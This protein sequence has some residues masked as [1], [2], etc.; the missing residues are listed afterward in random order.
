MAI[1]YIEV[2]VLSTGRG[3][4]AVGLGAYICR[5][6]W[7]SH[8]TGETYNFLPEE[9]KQAREAAALEAAAA[10]IDAEKRNKRKRKKG[11][12][13]E[14][15]PRKKRRKSDIVG[16]PMIFLPTGAPKRFKDP[17]TLWRAAEAAEMTVDRE[18]GLPRPKKKATLAK[19]V[20][21]ALPKNITDDERRDLLRAWVEHAYPGVAVMAVIHEADDPEIGN[22]H[23]HLLIST[24]T[25]DA[26]GFG[27]K[28]T[29]LEPKFSYR[30]GRSV[31]VE[32]QDL[33][34]QWRNFQN[35]FF[36]DRGIPLVVDA[37]IE[38]GGVHWG[39]ARFIPDSVR[40][41]N[42]EI[43]RKAARDRI[44]D[45][46]NL[47]ADALRNRATFT[48]RGLRWLLKANNVFGQEASD[49]INRV[50]AD[51]EVIPL[52]D[53]ETGKPLKVYTTNAVRNQERLILETARKLLGRKPTKR[54]LA[55]LK[56]DM[57]G[58]IAAMTFSSEQEVAYEHLL[59]SGRIA[60]CR[61]IAGAGKSHVIKG[62]KATYEAAGLRVV[63]LAPTNKVVNTMRTEGFSYANTLHSERY[64]L[65]HP[66]RN[67]LLWNANTVVVVDE[68]GMIDSGMM[69]WLIE[70]AAKTGAKLILVGDE[71]QLTSVERGGMFAILKKELGA[72]ELKEV[73]RQDESW[74]KEA[75]LALSEGRM[76][77]A[78]EAYAARDRIHWSDDLDGAM[79]RLVLRWSE[80]FAL[81]PDTPK[82]VYCATNVVANELNNRLQAIQFAGRR[83]FM[84]FTCVRGKIRLFPEDQV[85]FH[86]TDKKLG[87]MNGAAG[88]V[89]SMAPDEIVVETD[90]GNMITFDPTVFDGWGLGRCGTVY[91]GQG[92]T[93]PRTYALY[94]RERAWS[95]RSAY[96]AM[97]RHRKGFDL[98][99]PKSLASDLGQLGRQMSRGDDSEA[100]L[101][102]ASR[103]E[104]ATLFP[105]ALV[106]AVQEHGAPREVAAGEAAPE[107]LADHWRL[108]PHW[109]FARDYSALKKAAKAAS[110]YSL[111]HA[112]F[113]GANEA[114]LDRGILPKTGYRDPG[115]LKDFLPK[116][117]RMDPALI[118][119]KGGF[120]VSPIVV[121]IET[122]NY[123][124][125]F[126][127]LRRLRQLDHH[128]LHA[129][130][131]Q[132]DM[133]ASRINNVM[134]KA[135][136]F[137]DLVVARHF[138]RFA[139]LL[140][141]RDSEG[142]LRPART[143]REFRHL[144][145]LNPVPRQT[146]GRFRLHRN[147]PVHGSILA[148]VLGFVSA[149]NRPSALTN[150]QQ[151]ASSRG[152]AP[153]NAPA[154]AQ[155]Q[156]PAIT[157]PTTQLQTPRNVP[158]A[159]A[160]PTTRQPQRPA[161][162][163]VPTLRPRTPEPP[164]NVPPAAVGPATPP[165]QRPAGP[166]PQQPA[167]PP[168]NDAP[169]PKSTPKPRKGNDGPVI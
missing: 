61:G 37:S 28:A 153:A 124:A 81:D 125:W 16:R 117:P 73:R 3:E 106:K 88:K 27:K 103:D 150:V 17:L 90:A 143:R 164:K 160:A 49:L 86:A 30:A 59:L 38:A 142:K 168:S 140:K 118:P 25:L 114:A 135:D 82:F 53:P 157:P 22:H 12:P 162:T 169:L 92:Q 144:R 35:R 2:R 87:I 95:R 55:K 7:K 137:S 57:P 56:A 139:A 108:T 152:A 62:I 34:G 107:A 41:E 93:L 154:P 66:R 156:R 131:R 13:R 29:Y 43:T 6:R 69:Q 105:T 130:E 165:P 97:T 58:R 1:N 32:S 91:R 102:Y 109:R 94:D 116:N 166:A 111:I 39:E 47:L 10:A 145:S 133:I 151:N 161:F 40:V 9:A 76:S 71:A 23:A 163:I 121:N 67:T 68:A 167:P 134:A 50:L 64:R 98:F 141:R 14:K 84:E 113:K 11:E 48:R 136:L 26:E 126:K 99:V 15:K 155:P 4:S 54:Q 96:V 158:P 72:V 120:D 119:G 83:D 42:D 45:P 79:D 101:T 46:K 8:L 123:G 146:Y 18:D 132:L 24:R 147:H 20:V 148:D 5:E 70:T 149:R 112:H 31:H 122:L 75:S 129:I 65:E 78:V 60:I 74:A 115:C 52:F 63:G 85:Q 51:P 89:V 36:R 128:V 44:L 138:V 110:P 127:I 104:A 19:H 80:D 159:A 100:S 33:P 77:E 21:L